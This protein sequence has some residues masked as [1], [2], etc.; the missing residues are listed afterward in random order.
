MG[1]R[2]NLS[3]RTVATLVA[4]LY[5]WACCSVVVREGLPAGPFDAPAIYGFRCALIGWMDYPVGWLANP[6]LW[7]GVVLLACGVR[8]AGL[9]CGGL[10]GLCVLQWSV[11]WHRLGQWHM[12]QEG[13][14]LWMASVGV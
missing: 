8:I 3:E 10:A 1:W 14:Y 5:L 4:G 2:Q 12:I 13:Y 11:E 6:L 7:L 9:V